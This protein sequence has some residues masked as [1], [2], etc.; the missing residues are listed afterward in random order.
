VLVEANLGPG[1]TR[2]VCVRYGN[3]VAS[4]G[5]VVPLLVDQVASGG[6]LTLTDE[7]MT[8]Y[9]LTL[10]RAVDTVLAVL[11]D[12]RAGE[13][14]TAPMGAA[15]VVDLIDVIRGGR[16]IPIV[17]TGIRPG[18]KLHEEIISAEEALRAHEVDGWRVIRP[19]LP[20][21]DAGGGSL[22]FRAHTSEDATLEPLA[23]A[24]LLRAA[25]VAVED[26]PCA[27]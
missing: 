20:A 10:D 22:P 5:S 1:D 14:W 17:T 19:L 12:G 18:E 3:V 27:S 26:P 9:L 2:F 13:I 8:R 21:L 6:P 16:D 11:R 15:R 7:R 24:A 25:G 23:I 4:R